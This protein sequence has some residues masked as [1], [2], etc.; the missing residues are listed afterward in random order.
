MSFSATIEFHFN[1]IIIARPNLDTVDTL[2]C[3]K[4]C[5]ASSHEASRNAY[6]HRGYKGDQYGPCSAPS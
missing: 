1:K 2:S 3:V 4:Q 6:S 5:E